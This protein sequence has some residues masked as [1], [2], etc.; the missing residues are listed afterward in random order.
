MK[1]YLC[2]AVL[3]VAIFLCTYFVGVQ[4][5]LGKCQERTSKNEMQQQ[6]QIMT[7]QG[8]VHAETVKTTVGDIRRVL[9]EKYTIAE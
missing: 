2:V 8:G 9:R 3:G 5:G 4:Y 7:I 1:V 6:T